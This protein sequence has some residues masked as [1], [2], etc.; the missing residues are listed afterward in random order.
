MPSAPRKSRSGGASGFSRN[1]TSSRSDNSSRGSLTSGS[2]LRTSEAIGKLET[3]I[4][5]LQA[6]LEELQKKNVR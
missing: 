6:K 1:S 4:T 2:R 3:T 5:A